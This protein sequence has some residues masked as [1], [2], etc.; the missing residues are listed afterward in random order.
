MRLDEKLIRL[1]RN[2]K[3]II[4]PLVVR[5]SEKERLKT[6]YLIRVEFISGEELKRFR[7]EWSFA[8][9]GIVTKE[10]LFQAIT[11]QIDVS[12]EN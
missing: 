4:T 2:V 5:F 1:H 7:T 9:D 12:M 3:I 10:K 6:G 8:R 11:E